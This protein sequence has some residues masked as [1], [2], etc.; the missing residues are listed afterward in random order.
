MRLP[1]RSGIARRRRVRG[2]ALADIFISY[3]RADRDR[4]EKLAAA[5]E[6]EGYSVWWDHNID[7]GSEFSRDIERELNA[8]KAVVVCWSEAANDS[9]WV[10]DEAS[11]ARDA[12][13][14]I[15]VRLDT[16][17]APMGFRQYQALDIADWRGKP[18][19]PRS[20]QSF[21]C[22]SPLRKW[23]ATDFPAGVCGNDV[24]D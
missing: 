2:N 18:G 22:Q 8:A 24:T 17:Q 6:A 23:I 10:K 16:Q 5:L 11:A 3:A 20:F 12:G 21:F 4:I 7:A 14:L 13:K 9:P 19:A 15:P 1:V